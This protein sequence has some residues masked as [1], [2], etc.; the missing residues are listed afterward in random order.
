MSKRKKLPLAQRIARSCGECVACCYVL[1]IRD[2]GKP[3]SVDCR[4]LDRSKKTECCSIY[5]ERPFDCQQYECAWLVDAGFGDAQHRP[6][7]IG[8]LFTPRDNRWEVVPFAGPTTLIA[9]ETRSGAF[10][11]D[12]AAK[13]MKHVAGRFLVFGFHGPR[14]DKCRAMGPADKLTAVVKWCEDRGLSDLTHILKG[15]FA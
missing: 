3:V 6:D 14:L 8:V 11:E 7:R 4:H 15:V 1:A 9:H 5:A 13:F 10:E 12:Q 2:L